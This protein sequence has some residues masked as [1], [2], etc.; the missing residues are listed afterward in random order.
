MKKAGVRG[1]SVGQDKEGEVTEWAIDRLES[2]RDNPYLS[3][4][5]A[6]FDRPIKE[7]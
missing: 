1:E 6:L 7:D 4:S 3:A 5:I 2:T